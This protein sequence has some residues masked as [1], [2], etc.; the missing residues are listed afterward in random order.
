MLVDLSRDL[1]PAI[2]AAAGIQWPNALYATNPVGFARDILGVNPWSKQVEILEAVANG[3]HDR[4]AVRS[5]HKVGKSHSA[6]ILALWFYCSFDAAR[7]VMTSTTARQV[8]EILWREI[9]MMHARSGKCWDCKCEEKEAAV[10]GERLRIATPCPHSALIGGE[11]AETARSGFRS[12][13]STFRE[14]V[15]FTARQAEAV[16]GISGANLLYICDEASGIPELVYEAIE[17]NRFGRARIVMFSNPTQ[18]EGSFYDAFNSKERFFTCITVPST[19]TPNY[20]ANRTIIPGLAERTEIDQKAE[21]WGVK[22]ALYKIR[23]KGEHAE[24]EAGR[25][26]SV[27]LIGEAEKRWAETASDGRLYIGVDPAGE[28]GSGDEVAF[29]AR[30]GLKCLKF[31]VHAGLTDVGHLAATLA[32]IT[33]LK[34]P[35]ETPVVC[36]DSEG[37]VGSKVYIAL[38]NYAENNPGVL[39]LVRVRASDKSLRQPEVYHLM[40]DALTAAL[41][42]W[43]EAGGAIPEDA[44]LEKELHAMQWEQ[45]ADGKLRVTAKL[46]LKKILGRSPDRYD[47][48]ALSCWEPLSLREQ[49]SEG[50]EQE[51]PSTGRSDYYS[52][53]AL[54]PYA[55]AELWERK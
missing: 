37:P 5:G 50:H 12:D 11:M 30:R 35:R 4:V 41:A 45:R 6:A 20:I 24:H 1:L 48:L 33:A 28:A 36:V 3:P 38:K 27:H 16:A 49:T 44:K 52:E 8:D 21:E 7:V 18:N 22:S 51:A 19:S 29:A 43:F 47:A 10:R 42:A 9:R 26:F 15:G 55:G 13:D 17:G 31:Q 40:R 14:V 46:Q 2:A 53:G 25:I 39:E 34:L 54:D 32:M 23:V